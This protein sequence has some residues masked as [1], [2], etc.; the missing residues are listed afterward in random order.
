MG[1]FMSV[2]WVNGFL[3]DGDVCHFRLIKVYFFK[4][5]NTVKSPYNLRL[6]PAPP[7]HTPQVAQ[8]RNMSIGE[9]RICCE[10]FEM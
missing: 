2:L 3:Y 7:I 5:I 4:K 8:A 10:T 6:P 9:H 1:R